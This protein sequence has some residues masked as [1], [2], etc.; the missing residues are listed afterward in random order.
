MVSGM[1][2]G[3]RQMHERP[4]QAW[5]EAFRQRNN[6]KGTTCEEAL[7]VRVVLIRKKG[8]VPCRSLPAAACISGTV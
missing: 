7:D 2:F 5:Q 3:L 4:G 6:N 8:V 1:R